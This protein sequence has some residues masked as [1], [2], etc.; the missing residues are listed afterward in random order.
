MLT[1]GEPSP[2]RGGADFAAGACRIEAFF[3]AHEDLTDRARELLVSSARLDVVPWEKIVAVRV[4]LGQELEIR[5]LDESLARMR[6]QRVEH[7]ELKVPSP[8]ALPLMVE[9]FREK[10]STEKLKDRLDR[11]LRDMEKAADAAS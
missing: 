6:R 7:I 1:K 8:F 2:N 9:R 3:A 4:F 5:R 10:L 11:L